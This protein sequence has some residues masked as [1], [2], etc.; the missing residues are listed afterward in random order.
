M[1]DV[2]PGSRQLC[3]AEITV[4]LH[5]ADKAAPAG[6]VRLK[7]HARAECI[8]AAYCARGG[9]SGNQGNCGAALDYLLSLAVY[10]SVFGY[11]L[12]KQFQV[13]LRA[14]FATHKP[15]YCFSHAAISVYNRAVRHKICLYVR[16]N[17]VF[18][19]GVAHAKVIAYKPGA[20]HAAHK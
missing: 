11:S 9:V 16:V 17:T 1:R 3:I 2:L 10:A 6:I 8:G 4:R 14:T 12:R 15:G 5:G 19:L 13:F 20:K 18:N 7:T